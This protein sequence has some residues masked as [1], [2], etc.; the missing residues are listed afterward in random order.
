MAFV[1]FADATQPGV[2]IFLTV[3]P[4]ARL[5]SSTASAANKR[6]IAVALA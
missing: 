2:L 5:A 1:P 6:A 3:V 4:A